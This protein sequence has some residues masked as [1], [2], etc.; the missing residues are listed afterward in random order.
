M[1]TAKKTLSFMEL[2]D[3]FSLRRHIVA[4]IRRRNECSLEDVVKRCKSFSRE[5]VLSEVD[6]LARSGALHVRYKSK[7]DYTLC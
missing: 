3:E 5:E 4:I 2:E 7:G 6:R 1:A